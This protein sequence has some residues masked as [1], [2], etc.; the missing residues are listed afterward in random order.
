MNLGWL[1]KLH[2]LDNKFII[3]LFSTFKFGLV[4]TK[5]KG[6]KGFSIVVG[7]LRLELQINLSLIQDI[8]IKVAEHETGKA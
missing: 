7:I 5:S 8:Q 3:I 6:F 4:K 2:F 1:L